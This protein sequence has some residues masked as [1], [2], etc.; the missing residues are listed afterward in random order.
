MPTINNNAFSAIELL[1][2]LTCIALLIAI[3]IPAWQQMVSAQRLI[4]TTETLAQDLRSA[5][6]LSLLNNTPFY[7]HFDNTLNH[8]PVANDWCYV[9]STVSDC[10]CL[11][12]TTPPPCMIMPDHLQHW[13]K[14]SDYPGIMMTEV[15][16]G[17]HHSIRFNPVRGT[18]SFGHIRLENSHNRALL[19]Y[20]SLIGRIRICSPV[21]VALTASYPSC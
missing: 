16:F 6:R 13:Q 12:A 14:S 5:R 20:V 11:N 2:G 8:N 15:V 9:L 17:N 19:I 1:I 18:A 10:H 21:D 7:I 4:Q 3:A